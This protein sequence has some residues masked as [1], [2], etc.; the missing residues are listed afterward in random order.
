[1]IVRRSASQLPYSPPH[2][3]IPH[4]SPPRRLQKQTRFVN[5]RQILGI[6]FTE[7]FGLQKCFWEFAFFLFPQLRV[8]YPNILQNPPSIPDWG[9]PL[10]PLVG[11]CVGKLF[12]PFHTWYFSHLD[13]FSDILYIL[14]TQQIKKI[15]H[16]N[17]RFCILPQWLYCK[18]V[19]ILPLLTYHIRS[20]NCCKCISH[21]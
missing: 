17:W 4:C 16:C 12:W 9:F 13:I 11:D 19:L 10:F 7:L 14:C 21:Q 20:K 6:F 3:I 2:S 5:S 15:I 8:L 1:M 18:V